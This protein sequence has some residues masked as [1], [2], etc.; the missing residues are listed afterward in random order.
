MTGLIDVGGGMRD[1]YGAGALDYFLDNNI[2][3]DVCI[4]VS[5]GSANIAS[6]LAG[7]RGRTYSFYAEYAK[8]K[9]YM[10]FSNLFR[11]GSYFDLDYIYSFLSNEDGE[12]PIDFKTLSENT[13][14]YY[15]VVT[16]AKTGEPVY[17]PKHIITKNN[18][19]ALKASCAMPVACQPISRDDGIYFDGGVSDPIPVQKALE[20]GCDKVYVIIPRPATKKNREFSSFMKPFLSKYPHVLNLMKRRPEIY[21]NQLQ[22]LEHYIKKGQVVLIAPDNDY[23]VNMMTRDSRKLDNFYKKGYD[24]AKKAFESQL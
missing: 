4:G 16:D 21:N 15:I 18:L 9:E 17:L 13:S 2:S 1:I 20:L 14:A 7:Q 22:T 24:D 3:F 6:F 5:A 19:W 12:Y 10:S 23:D 8:R 11:N